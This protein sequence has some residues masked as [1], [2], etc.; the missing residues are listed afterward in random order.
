M[1]SKIRMGELLGS[2]AFRR[3]TD[4]LVLAGGLNGTLRHYYADLAGFGL[5][6]ASLRAPDSRNIHGQSPPL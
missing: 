2:A 3:F 6:G 5:Y 4:R 1:M